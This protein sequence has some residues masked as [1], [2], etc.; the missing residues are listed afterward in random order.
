MTPG[1]HRLSMAEY[2][3]LPAVSASLLQRAIDECPYAAWHASWLNPKQPEEASTAEQDVGSVAHALLLEGNA[4]LV[5]VVDAKDW[6]TNAA[7]EAR[8]EAHARG[9]IALLPHQM[10][11]ITAMVASATAYI[12]SLRETEPAIW[13]AFQ[14]GGGDSELVMRWDDGGV[15]CRARPDRWSTDR[16]VM[17]DVKTCSSSAEPDAWGRMQLVRNGYYIGA[18]FY[19][20]GVR[21]LFGHDADY[22]YLVIEQEAPHLCSLVGIDPAGRDLGERKVRR[23]LAAWSS[24]LAT[25]RWPAYPNRVAYPEFPAYE[26]AREEGRDDRHGIAYDPAKLFERREPAPPGDFFDSMPDQ[27]EAGRA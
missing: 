9:K 19:R 4:D 27:G 10:P 22:V 23:G 12:E 20:R 6:R 16:K 25:G 7:K 15:P 21:K 1:I 2:L 11:V 26:L 8:A 17:I 3:R 14:P 13:A 24:G 18:A 5:V